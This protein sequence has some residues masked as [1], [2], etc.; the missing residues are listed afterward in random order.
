MN[1]EY[2]TKQ[3]MLL[4]EIVLLAYEQN[5]DI[6]A[7]LEKFIASDF[8]LKIL[9]FYEIKFFNPNKVVTQFLKKH[10]I[11]NVKKQEIEYVVACYI[12]H[13]Y[14]SFYYRTNETIQSIIKQLTINEIIAN[15]DKYH[16]I[17]EER[18]IFI[19]K[20]F[21][22]L[23]MN[24]IRK[25]RA[26][27]N[28]TLS[29]ANPKF[30]LFIAKHIYYKLYKYPE[31]DGLE[32]RYMNGNEYL[33]S[34]GGETLLCSEYINNYDDIKSINESDFIH[35][36]FN[37]PNN[38][39]FLFTDNEKLMENKLLIDLFINQPP[40]RF[41]KIILYCNGALLFVNNVKSTKKFYI[42]LTNL[43]IRKIEEDF[44][45]N[46]LTVLSKTFI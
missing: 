12:V 15:Y 31:I 44:R 3:Y 30:N 14:L 38:I 45:N 24:P 32:Y 2:K 16:T 17:S 5:Y 29:F 9:L 10:S 41:D 1:D 23:K 37:I 13:I 6:V 39:L 18:V 20:T 4:K 28:P 22:N 35:L 34:K 21:Y 33:V 19:A 40:F 11:Q 27:S 42:S 26:K 8:F 36:R 43:D 7:F 25:M 46:I